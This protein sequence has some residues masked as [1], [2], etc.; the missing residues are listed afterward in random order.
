[1]RAALEMEHEM[2]FLHKYLSKCVAEAVRLK[3]K[4]LCKATFAGRAQELYPAFPRSGPLLAD[5]PFPGIP[6]P[7]C[8]Y[9]SS[10]FSLPLSGHVLDLH[11]WWWPQ[12]LRRT[13]QPCSPSAGRADSPSLPAHLPTLFARETPNLCEPVAEGS[14]RAEAKIQQLSACSAHHFRSSFKK[15]QQT[16]NTLLLFCSLLIQRSQNTGC[17]TQRHHQAERCSPVNHP[18]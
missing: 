7:T 16:G 5:G 13:P 4:V 11:S 14:R 9:S 15:M 3:K 10:S 2:R 6:A 8:D 17:L 12:H 18:K 1:M